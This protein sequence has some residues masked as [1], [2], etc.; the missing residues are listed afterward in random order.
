[1]AAAAAAAAKVAALANRRQQRRPR[2]EAP[3]L[4]RGGQQRGRTNGDPLLA[5][6]PRR[7]QHSPA[8]PSGPAK[9][10]IHQSDSPWLSIIWSVS[11]P[12]SVFRNDVRTSLLFLFPLSGCAVDIN[13]AC[14]AP[15][16][17]HECRQQPCCFPAATL[18]HSLSSLTAIIATFCF[19]FPFVNQHLALLTMLACKAVQ[20]PLRT[21]AQ[22]HW[23][24]PIAKRARVIVRSGEDDRECERAAKNIPRPCLLPALLLYRSVVSASACAARA[25]LPSKVLA[26]AAGAA[27]AA[28]SAEESR[29]PLPMQQLCCVLACS[30]PPSFG[31]L[32][33]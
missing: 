25:S 15:Y 20:G 3:R 24:R 16:P 27:A 26:P 8:L 13:A 32:P 28:A 2:R 33:A 30:S 19:L 12:F 9:C 17:S 1:M 14:S 11:I 31:W 10:P 22:Q 23:K 21:A 5:L 7:A 29:S 18:V 4:H 6:R